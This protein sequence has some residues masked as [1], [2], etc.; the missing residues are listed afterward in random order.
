M[1]SVFDPETRVWKGRELP[2]PFPLDV[3]VSELVL[4]SLKKTPSRVSQISVDDGT[5]ETCDELRIKIIR[6]AQNLKSLGIKD[7]DVVGV[8]C[9]NTVDLMAYI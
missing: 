5:E 4:D 2:W 1:Q 7:E 8:V 6:F 3:H 9:S